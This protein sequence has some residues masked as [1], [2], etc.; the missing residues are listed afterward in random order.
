MAPAILTLILASTSPRRRQLLEAAGI[1]FQLRTAPIDET[2][3]PGEAPEA[4]VRRLAQA[5]AAAVPL[6]DGEVILA[7]DTVVALDRHILNKP[8][9]EVDAARMLRLL[10]GR[11]HTVFTG[12]CFR[13][14]EHE[15]VDV[16]S[17]LVRFAQLSDTEIAA[18]LAS[19]EWADKAGGYAVQGLTSKFIEA[20]AYDP[21]CV[22]GLPV[23]LVYRHLKALGAVP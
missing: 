23:S 18:Y 10:S 12:I 6:H 9:G 11:E 2:P 1:P 7:A 15:V 8:E 22:M 5:K 16:A 13:T 4:L 19:E 14:T 17:S 20:I 21:Y 3:L